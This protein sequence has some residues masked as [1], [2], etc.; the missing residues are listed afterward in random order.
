MWW[1]VGMFVQYLKKANSVLKNMGFIWI[2]KKCIEQKPE[3]N[4]S[5]IDYI[6]IYY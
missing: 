1:L 5:Y 4:K 6:F 3:G 2:Y